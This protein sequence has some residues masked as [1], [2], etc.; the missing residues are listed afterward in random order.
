MPKHGVSQVFTT[1]A[2]AVVA[3]TEAN[4]PRGL[5]F[6]CESGTLEVLVDGEVWRRLT[7]GQEGEVV[8]RDP[9]LSNVTARGVNASATASWSTFLQ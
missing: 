8:R 5:L 3:P 7:A 9:P 4:P 6:T 1:T 2:S